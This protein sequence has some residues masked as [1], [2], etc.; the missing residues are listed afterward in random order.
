M[1]RDRVTFYVVYIQEAHPE[2]GWQ[3]EMNQ[4]EGVV[5]NQPKTMDER[6]D[7]ADACMVN[8]ELSMPALIDE[9]ANEVD[10]A[11]AALPDRLYLIDGDGRIAYRSEQGP[12]GFKPDELEAAINGHLE[13]AGSAQ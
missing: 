3:M 7:V 8:M 5:Y 13:V 1:Y 6:L 11:Y 10:Q 4:R 12:R 2:D 9:M